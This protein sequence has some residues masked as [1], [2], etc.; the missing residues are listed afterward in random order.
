MVRIMLS[1]VADGRTVLVGLEGSETDAD[2]AMV[3][4]ALAQHDRDCMRDAVAQANA[5]LLEQLRRPGAGL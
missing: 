3:R 1:L 2:A 5:L 4:A